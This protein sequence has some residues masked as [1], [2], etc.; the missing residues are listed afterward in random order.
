[1]RDWRKNKPCLLLRRR[2][3]IKCSKSLK[4]ERYFF[5]YFIIC[6]KLTGEC[7]MRRKMRLQTL[8]CHFTG[9]ASPLKRELLF[10]LDFEEGIFFLVLFFKDYIT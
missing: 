2:L 5:F 1:M 10:H 8:R 9:S 4:K 7:E 3:K 6:R